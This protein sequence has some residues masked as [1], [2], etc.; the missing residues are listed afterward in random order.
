M[1]F[2]GFG[3][4]LVF[5]NRGRSRRWFRGRRGRWDGFGF[6]HGSARRFAQ[7]GGDLCRRIESSANF[8]P[9]QAQGK[10]GQRVG[11]LSPL[12]RRPQLSARAHCAA[13][14]AGD[15]KGFLSREHLKQERP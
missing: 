5:H 9:E 6:A 8:N 10:F 4:R 2:L 13:V 1:R 15:R 14:P 12:Q 7:R 11:G 3:Q